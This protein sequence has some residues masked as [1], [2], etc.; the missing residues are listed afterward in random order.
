[1]KSVLL[2][3]SV[4][5]FLSACGGGGGGD[6]TATVETEADQKLSALVE[7]VK[8]IPAGDGD[9]LEKVIEV[10]CAPNYVE[11]F[12]N[13]GSTA[14]SFDMWMECEG[15]RTLYVVTFDTQTMKPTAVDIR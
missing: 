10:I 3:L 7:A 14:N 13:M 15:T 8:D 5:F 2:A 4:S 12:G 6:S 1:M 9:N 11:D